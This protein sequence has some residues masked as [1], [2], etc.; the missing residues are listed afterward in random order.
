MAWDKEEADRRWRKGYVEG[1]SYA[2]RLIERG[3]NIEGLETFMKDVLYPWRD[4]VN[5]GD[6]RPPPGLRR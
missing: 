5:V 2:L 4:D 6:M 1:F 3:D